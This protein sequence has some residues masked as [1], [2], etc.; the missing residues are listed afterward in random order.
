[1]G[2]LAKPARKA[3][4]YYDLHYYWLRTDQSYATAFEVARQIA[5]DKAEDEVYR[6]G[7]EGFDHPVIY[8]GKITTTY[9]AYSDNLVMFFLKGTQARALPR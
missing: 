8:E 2:A 3:G 4:L 6:R 5:G 9:K 7:I 1:M